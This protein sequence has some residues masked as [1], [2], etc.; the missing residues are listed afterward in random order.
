[1]EAGFRVTKMNNHGSLLSHCVAILD[2]FDP[3]AF[4]VDQHVKRYLNAHEVLDEVERS[5]IT[6]VFAGCV[7]HGRIM[8]VIVKAFYVRD[9]RNCLRA[10]KIFYTGTK[11]KVK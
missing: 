9:G 11:E 6:E 8:E 3:A 2:S 7:R 10:D 5:F 4:G 1:M